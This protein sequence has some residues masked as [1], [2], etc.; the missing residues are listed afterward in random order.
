[1]LKSVSLAAIVLTA[2]AAP[3]LAEP[4][5]DLDA[6]IKLSNEI[7][8]GADAKIKSEAEYAKY[9]LKHL[10]LNS[11]CGMRDF[12]GAEKIANE[13]RATFHLD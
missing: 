4:P 12:A 5:A 1:M 2:L 10:D 7:A 6:C 3:V 13:M 11:A 9:Y 8:K